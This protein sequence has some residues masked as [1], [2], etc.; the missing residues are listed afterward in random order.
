MLYGL[1]VFEGPNH[2]FYANILVSK[3]YEELK[4]LVLG[5]IIINGFLLM[6]VCNMFVGTVPYI[7]GV[8]PECFEVSIEAIKSKVVDLDFDLEKIAKCHQPITESPTTHLY[9]TGVIVLSWI[10]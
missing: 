6:Y 8:W 3:D 1:K 4:T 9:F 5:Q 10:F 7:N 2:L